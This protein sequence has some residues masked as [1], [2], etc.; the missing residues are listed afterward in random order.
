MESLPQELQ[1][2]ITEFANSWT[3]RARSAPWSLVKVYVAWI[4]KVLLQHT[5]TVPIHQ[6]LNFE[7]LMLHW[8]MEVYR[9]RADLT[10]QQASYFL[11]QICHTLLPGKVQITSQGLPDFHD[12]TFLTL[13]TFTIADIKF[14]EVYRWIFETW[15]VK[16]YRDILPMS[17]RM[18][19]SSKD[20][21]K[22]HQW[23]QIYLEKY[24]LNFVLLSLALHVRVNQGLRFDLFEPPFS[25]YKPYYFMDDFPVKVPVTLCRGIGNTTAAILNCRYI[26][27]LQKWKGHTER[28]SYKI[29][30]RV[31][32]QLQ[33]FL[34]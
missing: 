15:T 13:P 14:Q 5:Y 25:L 34:K 30:W 4:F 12:V 29:S 31:W 28:P 33:N 1:D 19:M 3:L 9:Q 32:N 27:D 18:Q 21:C 10:V 11:L 8:L 26:K 7:I 23:V 24:D 16:L 17:L 6:Q 20:I 2:N 22:W